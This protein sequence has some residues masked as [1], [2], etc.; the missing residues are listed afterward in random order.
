MP[1]CGDLKSVIATLNGLPEG[2]TTA[3]T[4]VINAP[5][6]ANAAQTLL[7][8]LIALSFPP[9]VG[10]EI[11]LH[12][13]YSASLTPTMMAQMNE[14]ILPYFTAGRNAGID[15]DTKKLVKQTFT[16]GTSSIAVVI[17]NDRWLYMCTM[18]SF[19]LSPEQR[20]ISRKEKMLKDDYLDA[21]ERHYFNLSPPQRVS[22]QNFCNTRIL[23]PFGTP[24][25]DFT[26]ANPAQ[27]NM[28]QGEWLGTEDY[29]PMSGYALKA[30]LETGHRHNV[31]KNDIYGSL[32]FYVR[33]QLEA[34]C[35]KLTTTVVNF[36]F[37]HQPI[38]ALPLVL[39]E[40][41][42]PFSTSA[43]DRIDASTITESL[44]IK[45]TLVALGPLLKTTTQNEYATLFT[46]HLNYIDAID[47][48]TFKTTFAEKRD[49]ALIRK[50]LDFTPARNE[51]LENRPEYH[52]WGPC[53]WQA[54]GAK[55]LVR[56]Y[57]EIFVHWIEA[58]I[59]VREICRE[60]GLFMGL[61][62]IVVG[63]WPRRFVGR[64][65]EEGVEEEFAVRM[66]EVGGGG[67][68]VLEWVRGVEEVGEEGGGGDEDDA[69]G[70]V[71]V[72]PATKDEK[73]GEKGE[74]GE[75][76][77]DEQQ[78]ASDMTVTPATKHEGIEA[79]GEEGGEV[80]DEEKGASDMTVTPATE[81]KGEEGDETIDEEKGA[82][83]MT[84]PPAQEPKAV[85]N[86]PEWEGR[87]PESVFANG[88]AP[89]DEWW[90]EGKWV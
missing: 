16:L 37:Y 88:P 55:D 27:F 80:G 61:Q 20:D 76:T 83:E 11:M 81:Q 49:T 22:A 23:L 66:Q 4:C 79:S 45:D 87:W 60:T 31:P 74:K 68:R 67:E 24:I 26:K 70:D 89:Y 36:H 25:N 14:K 75:E 73:I 43:F 5:G 19:D 35:N 78:G 77:K 84:V 18:L 21:R 53:Y 40:T 64:V 72:S 30:V 42:N 56:D 50:F 7:L 1:A 48:V 63:A 62:N 86:K 13:W 39:K 2:Y 90:T 38:S 9:P 34:F 65:G 6:A 51:Y 54:L 57:D 28:D 71:L 29:N 33:D 69:A 10:A 32:Y 8:L 82:S 52:A 41:L 59:G 47:A 44:G 17:E 3:L 58:M 46:H 12:V 85:D 15:Q